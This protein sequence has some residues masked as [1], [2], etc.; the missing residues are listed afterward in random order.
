M[1][2]FFSQNI[3]NQKHIQG[4]TVSYFICLLLCGIWSVSRLG[5]VTFKNKLSNVSAQKYPQD[6]DCLCQFCV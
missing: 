5:L 1:V 4:F 2:L 6:E 3:N